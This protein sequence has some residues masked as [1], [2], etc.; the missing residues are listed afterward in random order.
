M[1]VSSG[2][3]CI[4][5]SHS[6]VDVPRTNLACK[7]KLSMRAFSSCDSP[8]ECC[9]RRAA[10]RLESNHG[11]R[12]PMTAAS[13]CRSARQAVHTAAQQPAVAEPTDDETARL[14]ASRRLL[15]SLTDSGKPATACRCISPG[16]GLAL[17]ADRD[18]PPGAVLLSVPMSIVLMTEDDD[19]VRISINPSGIFL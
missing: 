1:A 18:V 14:E 3:C 2:H 8:K 6:S 9:S 16:A 12:A 17:V 5:M 11:H 15:N 4:K 13:L 10:Y 19:Q 7:R